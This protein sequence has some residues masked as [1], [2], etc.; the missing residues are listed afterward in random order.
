MNVPQLLDEVR[1]HVPLDASVGTRWKVKSVVTTLEGTH[2]IAAAARIDVR[3]GRREQF[4][5]DDLRVELGVLLRLTCAERECPHVRQVGAQWAAFHRRDGAA[6]R[7]GPPLP[8]PLVAEVAVTVGR[9]RFTARPARFPCF[10]PCPNAAHPPVT[11][12]K[13]GFDLFDDSSC[14]DG[15]VTES[16]GVRCPRFPTVGAAEA[17]LLARHLETLAVVGAA[18]DASRSRPDPVAG[19]D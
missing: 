12:E 10:T 13:S 4:W 15:G 3:G 8:R 19:A 18:R 6:T 2:H 7:P 16:N 11:I 9:Q 5:C 1:H 17:Y 14:L